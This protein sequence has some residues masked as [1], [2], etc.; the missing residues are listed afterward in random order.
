M[1]TFV[2]ECFQDPRSPRAVWARGLG[3][4]GGSLPAWES[5]E[6]VVQASPCCKKAEGD[7]KWMLATMSK[8]LA[9][10][11]TPSPRAGGKTE[12]WVPEAPGGHQGLKESPFFFARGQ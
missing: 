2:S 7:R 4:G 6:W 5:L 1:G 3:W 12:R 11:V 8:W 9:F 10:P